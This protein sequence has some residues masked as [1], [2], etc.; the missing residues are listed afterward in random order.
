MYRAALAALGSHA[1]GRRTLAQEAFLLAYRRLTGFRGD[2]SFKN[3]AA[4][5]RLAPGAI[6][7]RRSMTRPAAAGSCSRRSDGGSGIA[8]R[9]APSPRGVARGCGGAGPA[10]PGDSRGDL[11]RSRRKLRDAPLL[12][13]S[14]DHSYAEIGAMLDDAG[15]HDQSGACRRAKTGEGAAAVNADTTMG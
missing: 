6:N 11:D 7:R 13:Q 8:A 12:A 5:H 9:T 2:A 14:G 1:G 10:A 3:V 15:R 4:D